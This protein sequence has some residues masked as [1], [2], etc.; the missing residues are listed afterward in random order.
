LYVRGR[1][2]GEQRDD[3]MQDEGGMREGRGWVM[4]SGC[5]SGSSAIM[6]FLG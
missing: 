3:G 1:K 5:N 6:P 2:K 4:E